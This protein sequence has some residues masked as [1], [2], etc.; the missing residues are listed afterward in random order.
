[1]TGLG[2]EPHLSSAPQPPWVTFPR[3]RGQSA[4]YLGKQLGDFK[5]GA[6]RSTSNAKVMQGVVQ[7]LSDADAQALSAYLSTL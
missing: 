1:M 2:P 5:S 3:L 6:R 7:A 4:F